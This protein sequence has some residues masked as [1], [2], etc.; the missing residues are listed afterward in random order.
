M[1][2][3]CASFMPKSKGKI[4][5]AL[6]F[7]HKGRHQ[8]NDCHWPELPEEA[9]EEIEQLQARVVEL[10]ADLHDM[11]MEAVNYR[12]KHGEAKARCAELEAERDREKGE[13][14]GTAQANLSYAEANRRL[15]QEAKALKARVVE[16][17]QA[18]IDE[19]VRAEQRERLMFNCADANYQRVAELEQALSRWIRQLD[20]QTEPVPP[21]YWVVELHES[22]KLLARS[23]AGEEKR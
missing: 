17:E 8:F 3:R 22:I 11:C 13:R 21:V 15:G 12:I 5:C 20:G 7:S 10:E 19:R 18:A 4:Q 1:N 16:L 9:W 2:R 23:A 6:A 14:I